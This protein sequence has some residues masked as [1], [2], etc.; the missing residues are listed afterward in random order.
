MAA[1]PY[2]NTTMRDVVGGHTDGTI[3]TGGFTYDE[4]TLNELIKEWLALAEDYDRSYSRSQMLERVV[5][6]GKDY[7]SESVAK[8][9]NSYGRAYLNYLEQNRKYCVDQAQ[10]CQNALDEYLGIERRSVTGITQ[11]G[12][13]LDD[14]GQVF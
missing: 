8:A 14:S 5:G 12:H 4:I 2:R 10:L 13:A 1:D 6:P 9:A 7:V 3:A 11:A